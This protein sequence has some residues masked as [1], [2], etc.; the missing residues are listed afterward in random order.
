SDALSNGNAAEADRLSD[1]LNREHLEDSEVLAELRYQEGRRALLDGNAKRA[2]DRFSEAST[3]QPK[4]AKFYAAELEAAVA[5]NVGATPHI[6]PR[7]LE[8]AHLFDADEDVRFQLIRID[9][10]EGNYA[11]AEEMI[12][13][14]NGA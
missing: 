6:H 13:T 3:L 8:R 14:L 5:A 2:L 4:S 7:F 10:L 9:A 1:Q 12:A 11:K